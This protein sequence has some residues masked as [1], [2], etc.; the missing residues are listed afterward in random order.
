MS[1]TAELKLPKRAQDQ[2]NVIYREARRDI[3]CNKQRFIDNTAQEAK[4]AEQQ[5][6]MED[7]Y[8]IVSK[9]S[10]QIIHHLNPSR[11]QQAT[12]ATNFQGN[13]TR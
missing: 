11:M 3:K 4:T 5:H 7:L 10:A 6:R 8:D 12:L 9:L 13:K 1:I 2:H